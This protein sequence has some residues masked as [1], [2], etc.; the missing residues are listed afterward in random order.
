MP[1]R[2]RGTRRT[3]RKN[4]R[5][6]MRK[7]MKRRVKRNTNRRVKR[8]TNRR[9]KRNTIRRVKR[10]TMRRR[11]TRRNFRGGS[12]FD[13]ENPLYEKSNDDPN[14]VYVLQYS[15]TITG[16]KELRHYNDHVIS[17]KVKALQKNLKAPQG[18]LLQYYDNY[19]NLP[20]GKQNEPFFDAFLVHMAHLRPE[21]Y[22][23][24]ALDDICYFQESILD[25]DGDNKGAKSKFKVGITTIDLKDSVRNHYTQARHIFVLS[26]F[27]SHMVDE[28]KAAV[29]DRNTPIMIH[30]QG[31][32]ADGQ[33]AK[34]GGLTS[35]GGGM[36][37]E[38][39]NLF[40]GGLEAQK[41]RNSML[42]KN[43]NFVSVRPM[44]TQGK[45]VSYEVVTRGVT[46]THKLPEYYDKVNQIILDIATINA[47]GTLRGEAGSIPPITSVVDGAEKLNVHKV[48]QDGTDKDNLASLS[49]LNLIYNDRVVHA[50]FIGFRIYASS[51][52]PMAFPFPTMG[53]GSSALYT[54]EEINS[55]TIGYTPPDEPEK[56]FGNSAMQ[57]FS[58]APADGLKR[59][60]SQMSFFAP[61]GAQ[62]Q[63]KPNFVSPMGE[64]M[65]P[66]GDY[67]TGNIRFD[68]GFTERF[69]NEQYNGFKRILDSTRS[70]ENGIVLNNP[71][72][73]RA[74]VDGLHTLS[75]SERAP[76]NMSLY[77]FPHTTYMADALMVATGASNYNEAI[78]SIKGPTVGVT[79]AEVDTRTG[80]PS[81]LHP[82][83]T[84]AQRRPSP[85]NQRSR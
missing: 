25:S 65:K 39:F 56:P 64:F 82:S 4:L 30:I 68:R 10:N 49:L 60:N 26:P 9:V 11:N 35:T 81:A 8:N 66:S 80:I 52:L 42:N 67:G 45:E 83:R 7:G 57:P 53:K 41:F 48:Y 31:D 37:G 72:P 51:S 79:S 76:F 22:N 78:R 19:D 43:A 70:G 29:D 69:Y 77:W 47:K 5:K 59:K 21:K 63:G 54:E 44:V 32:A 27:T 2:S 74:I 55:C 73:E 13:M 15:G 1:R 34:D 40:S 75:K 71:G 46:T 58:D 28:I 23:D 16:G 18:T 33:L 62:T 50:D 24:Y 17:Q 85:R 84:R 12:S 14:P 61:R 38:A 20:G 36:F 6:S 3:N